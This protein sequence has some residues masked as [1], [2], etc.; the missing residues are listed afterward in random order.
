M[1]RI[2]LQE[3]R[4]EKYKIDRCLRQ[5]RGG[6]APRDDGPE[7]GAG[8]ARYELS[9]RV[10]AIS[11]GG[12]GAIH[13]LVRSLGLAEA[14]D[15]WLPLL[16]Q[17][18]PYHESDH[19][20]NIAYSF[21]CGGQS[22]DDIHRLRCD[23]G[24]LQ[25]LGARSLPAP[26]TA[27]DFCRRFTADDVGTLTGLINDARVK[28]WQR[29]GK[30]LLG[31]T[32]RID[33]DSSIVG[34][35]GECRK[36]MD[37]SYKGI[38]GYHPLLVSLANTNEP[39][40]LVNRS[41]NRPSSEGAP[42]LLDEAVALCRGAGF[43]NV[44]MRGDSAFSTTE[45]FDRWTEDGVHFV[46]GYGGA[47]TLKQRADGLPEEDYAK[48]IRKAERA[49]DEE[50][51][52]R[53]KQPRVKQSVVEE[54]GYKDMRLESEHIAEFAH[55]P[56]RAKKSYRMIVLRKT[57]IEER[58]QRSLG[59]NI[60]YFFYVTNDPDL[61]AEQVVIEANERCNQE[62]LIAQL[63]GGV[64]SLTTPLN[65]LEANWALMVMTTLAWS[66]KAWIALTMPSSPRWQ[67]R[68]DAEWEQVVRMDFRTF[69][70]DFMMIPA[71]I[72]N[73]GRRLVYRLL[74]WRPCAHILVRALEGS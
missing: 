73:T 13:N 23:G 64:R 72:V 26:T 65:T 24:Y 40:F 68:H 28:V 35:T 3:L 56:A 34:T 30:A 31:Q 61:T 1:N 59:T 74:A 57:I 44:L 53:A 37:M 32:A 21:L 10:R 63:K 14:L 62:N 38:W 18:R 60:R 52:R 7:L 29:R 25:A 39:L 43:K 69:V 58:Y 45:H 6:M 20:L 22:L 54:R 15:E 9:G 67:E 71:Q 50:K 17:H 47:P 42:E 48:L 27:G 11:F 12:I 33:V 36:G 46:F 51:V 2:L 8:R 19:V 41:G 16:S 5:A 49:L 70:L 4:A 55:T 66:L